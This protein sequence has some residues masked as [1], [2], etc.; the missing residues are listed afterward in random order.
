MW[1]LKKI[2]SL[3]KEGNKQILEKAIN[4]LKWIS[5]QNDFQVNLII[6]LPLP[7]LLFVF[8]SIYDN[9]YQTQRL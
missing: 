8:V 3:F 4:R 9:E 2:A 7:L 6:P 1:K 5:V